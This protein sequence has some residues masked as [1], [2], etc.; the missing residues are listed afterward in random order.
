MEQNIDLTRT[1]AVLGVGLLGAT[2]PLDG[3]IE[4]AKGAQI[5]MIERRILRIEMALRRAG[6]EVEAIELPK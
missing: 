3:G 5:N 4:L 6:I 1:L 2:S